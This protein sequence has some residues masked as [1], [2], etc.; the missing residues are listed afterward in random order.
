MRNYFVEF[1]S[2]TDTQIYSR[3]HSPHSLHIH[4]SKHR[5]TCERQFITA[6]K[7]IGSKAELLAIIIM[8]ARREGQNTHIHIY[9]RSRN[10]FIATCNAFL[11]GGPSHFASP[12]SNL[13]IY[14][15]D[16][17]CSF[18]SRTRA[19]QTLALCVMRFLLLCDFPFFVS[20]FVVRVLCFV[21][22]LRLFAFRCFC[23]RI[24]F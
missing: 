14:I 21:L 9:M 2:T 1:A 16:S 24:F 23:V 8:C 4:T 20:R 11:Y 22:V 7:L 6:V 5:Y 19:S 13:T 15:Y 3:I 12:I 17:R 18:Y 10:P